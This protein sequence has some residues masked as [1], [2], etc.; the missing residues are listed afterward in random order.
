MNFK[1]PLKVGRTKVTT[2]IV[3]YQTYPEVYESAGNQWPL[4]VR[5]E[6]SKMTS[7]MDARNKCK[8]ALYMIYCTDLMYSNNNRL[9]YNVL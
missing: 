1:A 8:R 7:K 5:A 2:L 3:I 4:L 9:F 6:K